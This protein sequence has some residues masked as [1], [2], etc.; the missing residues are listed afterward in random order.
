MAGEP[1]S[2]LTDATDEG[3]KNRQMGGSFVWAVVLEASLIY[4]VQQIE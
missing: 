1:S 3:R 4:P 2:N